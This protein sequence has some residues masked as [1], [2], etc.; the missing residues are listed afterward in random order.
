MSG[1]YQQLPRLRGKY[2]NSFLNTKRLFLLT[3]YHSK[4]P[5]LCGLPKTHKL[6]IPLRPRVSSIGYPCYA[7]SGFLHKPLDTLAGESEFFVNVSGYFMQLLKSVNLQSLDTRP[8]TLTLS[9]FSRIPVDGGAR[10]SGI[11]CDTMLNA[12]RSPVRF[13]MRSLDFSIDLILPAALWVQG[14]TQALTEMGT[15][16][17]PGG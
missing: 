11:G 15:E 1:V 3:A 6:D 13:L 14:S 16:N 8:L 2:R 7:T 10:R 9:V 5:R 4:A 12:R 17:L